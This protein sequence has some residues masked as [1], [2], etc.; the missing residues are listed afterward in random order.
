[1]KSDTPKI[2]ARYVFLDKPKNKQEQMGEGEILKGGE[3]PLRSHGWL[4]S[5]RVD[6][7]RDRRGKHFSV[8][9]Y[10]IIISEH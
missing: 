3:V 9:F 10:E 2:S 1:M 4:R 5:R 8:Y 6:G 7:N